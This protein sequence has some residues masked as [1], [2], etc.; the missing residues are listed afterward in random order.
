MTK[1]EAIIQPGYTQKEK[2]YVTLPSAEKLLNELYKKEREMRYHGTKIQHSVIQAARKSFANHM[3]IVNPDSRALLI[4]FLLT[5]W[6][7]NAEKNAYAASAVERK[8]TW[9]LVYTLAQETLE[10]LKVPTHRNYTVEFN[11][12]NQYQ[13]Y[14]NVTRQWVIWEEKNAKQAD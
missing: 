6:K 1:E 12:H 4:D 5:T 11:R 14:D 9:A 10:F 7:T 2:T 13:T 3:K 8:E